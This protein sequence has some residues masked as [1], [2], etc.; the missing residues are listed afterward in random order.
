MGNAIASHDLLPRRPAPG[1]LSVETGRVSI[2]VASGQT[3]LSA[4]FTLRLPRD[5]TQQTPDAVTFYGRGP[6]LKLAP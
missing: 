6:L 3:S 5:A 4:W 2:R 1:G